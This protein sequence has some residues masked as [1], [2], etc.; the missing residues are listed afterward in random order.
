[1]IR[2]H[3]FGAFLEVAGAG[4][5]AKACPGGQHII[6]WGRRQIPNTWPALEE[7]LVIGADRDDRRLLQHDLGEPHMVGIGLFARA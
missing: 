3:G 5:I 6:E 4:V 7:I 1:M 2:H